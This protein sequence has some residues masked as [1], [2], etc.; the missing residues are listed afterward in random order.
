MKCIKLIFLTVM[1]V[2][3]N[4]LAAT[5]FVRT[6]GGD[7]SQC[8][9]RSDTAYPGSGSAQACA[10][11]HPN[12]ALPSAGARIVGGDIVY[13]NSGTYIVSSKMAAIPSGA[14]NALTRFVGKSAVNPPKLVGTNGVVGVINLA[15]SSNVEVGNFEITDQHDCI[16]KYFDTAGACVAGGAWA[17]TGIYANSSRNVWVHDINIHGMAH[18]GITAGGLT[19]WTVERVKINKNGRVGWSGAEASNS[20]KIIMRNIEIG[21]NGCGERVATGEPWGCWG[22]QKG[23]YGDGFG[24]TYTGGQ[25]LIEDAYIHHN[26]SDGLDMR[27]Q[28]GADTTT[29]V[30]RRILSVAN[31][32]NQIKVAGNALIENSVAIGHCTY[33]KGKFSTMIDGDHCRAYGSA[34]LLILTGNDIVTVRHN[35]VYGEGDALIAYGEGASSD[36]INIH[37]NVGIGFPYYL[38]G[39]SRAFTAGGAPG[40]KTFSG[41]LGWNVA[42]CP[43]GSICNTSN[44][45]LTNMTLASFNAKPLAGSPVIDRAPVIAAVTTDFLNQPRPVGAGPDIGAYE[46]GSSSVTTTTTLPPVTTTTAPVTT[47]TTLPP[48]TTTTAPV[49]TTTQSSVFKITSEPVA[50][51]I[52]E[53]SALITWSLSQAGTGQVHY[54]TTT[55]YG[56]VTTLE[57]SFKFSTHTQRISG[58]LPGT[59]YHYRIVSKNASGVTVTSTG[60][61]FFTAGPR[62]L[63]GPSASEITASSALITWSLSE[64]ATGQVEYG[65]SPSY[66]SLSTPE[67]SFNFSTHTQRLT[68]LA[69]GKLYYYRVISKNAS[70]FSV[71]S[72]SRTFT[73]V[74]P[75]PVITSGPSI[76]NLTKSSVTIKWTL[77]KPATGQVEY[78]RTTSYGYKTKEESS[79]NYSSHSQTITG[80]TSKRT[81]HYR[82]ISKDANGAT[83]MSV[84]KSF[85]TP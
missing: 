66:G 16:N 33:F 45:M 67:N 38:T 51:E 69:A 83:V 73:T 76:S 37:N 82:V 1:L 14:T 48:V 65:L 55:A 42:S 53:S 80:L 62:I 71:V 85:T 19:D 10:W 64:Y 4:A 2:A 28:D 24:T 72:P 58:L 30:L 34:I 23:G 35:T 46:Y 68:G 63:S 17:H 84:D 74:N 79:L 32:G 44:P 18:T 15:G 8:T 78:G 40:V 52:T 77:S 5:Y 70:G 6:D 41:N 75:A 12:I 27:Y 49:T 47:T 22:Q 50:S 13:V 36:R 60:K 59:L 11:K 57:P 43:S 61:T 21:W 81:Y 7:A 20:G 29:V 56:K 54:G 26:T 39:A 9:G 3:S 31:A 25:W